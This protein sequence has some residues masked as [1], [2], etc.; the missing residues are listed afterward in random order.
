MADNKVNFLRGTS[1]EYEASTK[2]NDTFYYTT[3]D[4]KLYLGNK[5][6]TGGDITI[7]NTLS[8]TSK[9]PV[10]NKVITNALNTKAALASPTFTGTPKAPTASAGTNTTQIATTAFVQTAVSNGLAASD[11]MIIK[12]TIGTNGTV[13]A[14]PTTYKTGWTYRVITPGTYAGQICEVGDLIIALV[15]RSGLGN[16]NSDWCVAQTNI[17]GA[18]TGVKSGD[19]YIDARESGSVATITHKDVSRSNTTSTAKPSQGG[20]FTAVKSITSD[21]KGHITGVDTETVTIPAHNAFSNVKVDSTTIASDATT[22]TIEIAGSNVTLTPDATNDKLT[23]GITK[24][25][26]T[27]ALGYTPPTSDTTYSNATTSTAGLMSTT[28]KAKLDS[29]ATGAT[30]DGMSYGDRTKISSGNLNDYHNAGHYIVVDLSTAS[31][32][33]NSPFTDSGYFLDVYYRTAALTLQIAFTWS[34]VI[35]IRFSTSATKWSDWKNINTETAGGL[36]STASNKC[37]RNIYAGTSDMTAGT[38]ALETGAIYLVY[39]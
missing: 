4:E 34:G 6:I 5:E 39:E 33:T 22:D 1:A 27:S 7:D 19:A 2:D 20:T 30:T 13:T 11:A 31:G 25:N 3:D 18:I 28:D 10:Q 12:G 17:N 16:V 32:I 14:L 36:A 23:I 35:K 37:L 29:V 26:V 8:D 21:S 38:T 24:A 15:D 9:N